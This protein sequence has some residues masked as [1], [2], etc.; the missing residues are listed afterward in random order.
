M[1]TAADIEVRAAALRHR[2]AQQLEQAGHL[3]SPGWRSAVEAVPRHLFLPAFFR[4]VDAPDGTTMW[5]PVTA[6]RSG[7][8]E[9]LDL[10]YTDESLVTQLDGNRYSGDVSGPVSGVPTS[11]STMPSLVVRMW[12]DLGVVDDSRVLEIGTGTGYSTALGCHRLGEDRITSVEV[13]PQVAARARRALEGAGYRPALVVGDGLAGYESGAPYDRIIATCALRHVPAAWIAETRP[14]GLILLTLSGTL[15]AGGL[16]RIVVAEDGTAEGR[17]LDGDVSS[18]LARSYEEP[19]PL[20]ID[21]RADGSTERRADIDEG[22]FD[23]RDSVF[24]VQLAAPDARRVFLENG[25]THILDGES[26]ATV[27][28]QPDG[29]VVVRQKGPVRLWD[30]IERSVHAWRSAGSPPI[31]QFG[32]TVKP[33]GQTVWLDTPRG[34]LSWSLPTSTPSGPRTVARWR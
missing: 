30:Q 26:W 32:V 31:E 23:G 4:A 20:I 3:R 5:D 18:M 8:D 21:T 9:W 11:S 19:P 15:G 17:F 12:E 28:R 22:V 33:E 10:V 7:T 27:T 25:E 24:V 29:T 6:G 1:T 14:G 16:A 2:L 13:D 34:R